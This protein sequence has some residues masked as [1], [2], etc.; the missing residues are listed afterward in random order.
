[1]LEENVL[2]NKLKRIHIKDDEHHKDSNLPFE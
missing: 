2:F 1:M